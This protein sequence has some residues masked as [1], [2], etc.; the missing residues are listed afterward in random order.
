MRHLLSRHSLWGLVVDGGIVALSWWLAF[1]LRF[2]AKWPIF[3]VTLFRKTVLK[4]GPCAKR[5]WW[6]RAASTTA[7]VVGQRVA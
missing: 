4:S 3:Y 6:R 5:H 7:E 1:S 2:D